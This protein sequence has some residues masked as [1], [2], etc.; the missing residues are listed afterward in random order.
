MLIQRAARDQQQIFT[1]SLAK[2]WWSLLLWTL[3]YVSG[4]YMH[5]A[6]VKPL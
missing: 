5:S 3:P 1:H 2:G 4:D 6:R